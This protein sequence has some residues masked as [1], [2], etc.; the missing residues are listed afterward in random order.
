MRNFLSV[1]TATVLMASAGAAGA[2]A[3]STTAVA[4]AP[5]ETVTPAKLALVQRLDKAMNFDSMM[6]TMLNSMLPAMID[7]QRKAHPDMTDEQAR[8]V[9]DVA[10]NVLQ[11][12]IP[13]MKD[14]MYRTYA[15]TFSEDELK[16][17]VE[18]YESPNGQAVIHKLPLVMQRFMPAI[19]AMMP[20]MQAEMQSQI[21]AKLKCPAQTAPSTSK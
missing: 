20:Q 9:S 21:C 11:K 2:Q 13:Q 8:V 3:Q 15:E 4:A 1:A 10:V 5:A 18:F 14:A 6:G 7:A 12:Y 19:S 17:I 16:S